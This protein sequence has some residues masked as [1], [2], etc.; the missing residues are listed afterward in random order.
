M[1]QKPTYTLFLV[2]DGTCRT[3]EQ[4][5]RAVLV[6][7]P[8]VRIRLVKKKAVRSAEVAAAVVEAAAA[9]GAPVFYTL[10]EPETRAAIQRAAAEH[11]VACVDL[12]GPV[13]GNL[14]DLFQQSPVPTPGMLYRSNR[15][16]FDRI[17]AVEYT[18]KHD[19][20]RRLHELKDADVVLVGASRTSKST[21]CFY[22]AYSGIRAANVPLF[23]GSDPPKELLKIDPR[24]VIALTANPHRLQSVRE[25]RLTAW[26]QPLDDDYADL[27]AISR[28]LRT[29]MELYESQ[30]WR[31]IDVS[32]RA[33][34]EVA[35]EVRR[36]L[37]E[38]G[39]LD[40]GFAS[41]HS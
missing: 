6:Q 7:F 14:F 41:P 20:G 25:A 22:L 1:S 34:E 17:D 26:G 35:R 4:I 40:V 2:S 23:A 30:N 16:Y 15:E 38:A 32:Y 5:L 13:L 33:I 12:L 9:A 18:L 39:I 36:L 24:R 31:C 28:E 11:L 27:H 3:C 37:A 10:V 21:T 8:D 19:D 29:L